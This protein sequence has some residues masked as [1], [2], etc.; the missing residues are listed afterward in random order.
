MTSLPIRSLGYSLNKEEFRDSVSLRYG[1]NIPNT[2]AFCSCGSRNDVNHTLIC[3]SGGYVIFRHNKIRDTE[4]ELLKE[5][6]YDV[7]IEPELLPLEPLNFQTNGNNTD[8]ARLDIS[9]RGLWSTFEKTYFDVRV[10]HPN[11]PSYKSK[12]LSQLYTQCMKK[13]RKD[14]TIPYK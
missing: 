1:W 2:P 6:C 11:S 13:K 12:T 3:K 9:A 14:S 8:R 10:F 5:V 4:A 7:R